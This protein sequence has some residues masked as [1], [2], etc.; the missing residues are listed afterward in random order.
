MATARLICAR[1]A[2]A[3][4][5]DADQPSESGEVILASDIPAA[6]TAAAGRA[7]WRAGVVGRSTARKVWD[8]GSSGAAGK[9]V[10][11]LLRVERTRGP[12][13]IPSVRLTRRLSRRKVSGTQELHDHEFP[14][15]FWD[16]TSHER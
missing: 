13:A 11:V 16:T 8:R 3:A 9:G 2:A 10:C 5:P 12:G 1:F 4:T 14:C 15:P 6:E 7:A